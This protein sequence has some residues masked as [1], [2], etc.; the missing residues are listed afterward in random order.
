M[1]S[2]ASPSIIA[3]VNSQI[4]KID[5]IDFDIFDLDSIVGKKTSVYIASEILSKFEIVENEMIPPDILKNFIE[6]IVEHYDRVNAIYHNDLHAGDVMQTVFTIFIKGNLQERMKLGQLDTFAIIVAALCHDYKHTGQNNLFHINSKS[7]IAMRY[8]DISVL[9]N[10]HIAQTFKVLSHSN[11][12]IYKNFSPEEF[13]ICRRRMIE[14]VLA[15]DM[16]N[17]QTVLSNV[18]TKIASCNIVKGNNFELIF[19]N[20][21]NLSKLFEAQQGILNMIIH[22][23]D[24]SNPA[25]PDKISE[26]YDTLKD[27]PDGRSF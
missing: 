1:S 2:I 18:K 25:K 9:E 22:S 16:A 19:T 8:N 11:C 4:S 27:L 14:G 17:H 6:T 10:Y 26:K 5:Q 7:K 21:D 13:R 15:T 23:A 3:R 20:S 12:N 24:I